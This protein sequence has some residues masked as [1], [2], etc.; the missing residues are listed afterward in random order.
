MQLFRVLASALALVAAQSGVAGTLTP[1]QW[2]TDVAYLA[3]E[4]PRRHKNAFARVSSPDFEKQVADLHSR[5]PLLSEP[6]IRAGILKLVA[7]IGDAHTSI[8][9]W[10]IPDAF[11]RLPLTLYWFKDGV[12]VIEAP[13]QYR[14]L[15]G[16]KLERVGRVSV[17]EAC[18]TLRAYVSHENDA[19]LKVNLPA[20]LV[21]AELLHAAGITDAPD[22]ALVVVQTPA[23]ERASAE[24]QALPRTE[25]TEMLRAF[26]GEPPLYRRNTQTAYWATIIDGGATVYFQYNRCV[27][28]PE[29]PFA[30]FRSELRQMLDRNTVQRIVLD[31][32]ANPGG[33]SRLLGGW[34]R[35]IKSSR[36][37]RK[38]RLF[39]VIGRLTISSSLMNAMQLRDRTAA[40]LVGEPSGGKPSHFGEIR[41]F[42]LPHSR[43][44]INYSKKFFK[45]ADNSPS[46]MPEIPVEQTSQDYLAGA[47]PVL[48]AILR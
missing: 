42:E 32:R 18:R 48:K 8:S 41:S 7:S 5:I 4:L 31:L 20:R 44:K 2:Q 25:Q 35:E 10:G 47:D 38:G 16:G 9:S 40:T 28:D 24:V 14:S 19:W 29:R 11:R 26:Q 1:Q 46:L 33:N 36:F 23:G 34:I 12:F 22:R 39:V 15:L 43:I 45:S 17:D 27:N 21:T 3:R 13:P 30:R 6:E 37:N